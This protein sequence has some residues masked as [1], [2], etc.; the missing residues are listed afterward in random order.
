MRKA[1]LKFLADQETIESEQMDHLGTLLRNAPEPIGRIAFGY[2]M[3]TA[4]D[5]DE[6]LDEQKK[7]HRRFGEIATS[8]G[9]LTH[10]QVKTL[11]RIQELHAATET[12]EA[13]ALAGVCPLDA[14]LIQ[15]GQFLSHYDRTTVCAS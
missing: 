14:V 8:M 1:F 15:L 2:G 11:L 12:A 4:V 9:M 5:I 6:I 7:D 13:L 10:E 3:V